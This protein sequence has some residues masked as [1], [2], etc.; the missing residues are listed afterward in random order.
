MS[1]TITTEIVQRVSNELSVDY[2]EY[3]A[4]FYNREKV[5]LHTVKFKNSQEFF[6]AYYMVIPVMKNRWH[7]FY[8]YN[9]IFKVNEDVF[10][11]VSMEQEI[12][13][14]NSEVIFKYPVLYAYFKEIYSKHRLDLCL[15]FNQ[16]TL[17]TYLD[18]E[19]CRDIEFN[20]KDTVSLC[21]ILGF[22]SIKL[23]SGRE[24]NTNLCQDIDRI[25]CYNNRFKADTFYIDFNNG[26]TDT[27]NFEEVNGIVAVLW[28]RHEIIL[29]ET[30]ETKVGNKD[31][32][33]F[34]KYDLN[35]ALEGFTDESLVKLLEN[36]NEE[37]K[38]IG[39]LK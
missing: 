2:N 12:L 7:T 14:I 13:D 38:Q 6:T 16:E 23:K 33:A 4:V 20:K 31:V 36:K 1:D 29:E 25:W 27:I 15:N 35:K 3:C 28:N 30:G 5:K 11:T 18:T 10:S 32:V 24:Y 19:N 9:C 26:D 17:V 39:K 34:G 21:T 37:L 8:E 22:V